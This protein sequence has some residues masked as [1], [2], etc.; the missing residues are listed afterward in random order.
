MK[1]IT[2]LLLLLTTVSIGQNGI[3]D[4]KIKVK[5]YNMSHYSYHEK[6]EGHK[7]YAAPI[8][9]NS[10]NEIIFFGNKNNSEVINVISLNK[11]GN[12]NWAV[13]VNKKYDEIETQSVVQDS[14]GNTYAFVLSYNYNIYRGG[15]ERVI[16]IDSTGKIKWDIILGDYGLINSPHCSYIKLHEDGRLSLRGHI[17]MDKVKE[18][19]DPEYKS[20]QG[21]LNSEGELIQKIGSVIDWS[22]EDWK[23][24][25]KVDTIVI[26]KSNI[27]DLKKRV[28]EIIT[29]KGIVENSKIPTLLGVDI[30]IDNDDLFGKTVK[31]TGILEKTIVTEVDP[32][33]T[34]RGTG[35]FYRLVDSSKN[36]T[37]KVQKI[38]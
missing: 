3:K 27:Q 30:D 7:N 38:E 31:A 1:R 36:I 19:K 23:K 11:E 16:K 13:P 22:S 5:E 2:I 6:F 21:W 28:G 32:Y 12:L 9:V 24:Y 8:I 10:N 33:S 18:G 35:T 17:V 37:A 34:N 25:L 20:W 4:A 26:T 29:I 14:K 15:S